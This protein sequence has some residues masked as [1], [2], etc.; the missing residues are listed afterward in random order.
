MKDMRVAKVIKAMRVDRDMTQAEFA[1]AVGVYQA[2]V[3][4]WEQGENPRVFAVARIA[5]AF[6]IDFDDLIK[7]LSAEP[8]ERP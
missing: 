8:V 7:S 3:S 4:K 1:K 6:G 2:T 5:E